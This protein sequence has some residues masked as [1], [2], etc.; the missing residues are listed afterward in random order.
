M[1]KPVPQCDGDGVGIFEQWLGHGVR[2]SLV[3]GVRV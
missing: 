3:S 1:S 2:G